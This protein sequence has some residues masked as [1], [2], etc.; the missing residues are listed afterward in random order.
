MSFLHGLFDP[1]DVKVFNKALEIYNSLRQYP[2][3]SYEYRNAL[4]KII[5]LCQEAV[6][7]NPDN[8]DG[9][10]LLA[11]TYLLLH[12]DLY[13]NEVISVPLKLAAA[14]IQYWKNIWRLSFNPFKPNGTRVYEMVVN[15]I[16]AVRPELGD[17]GEVYQEMES[18]QR[19]YDVQ[20]YSAKTLNEIINEPDY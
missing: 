15:A 14:V 10:V 9:Y 13:S 7:F 1:K 11:N 20:A 16:T 12:L 8:E 3:F 4:V 5:V 19:V 6:T 17:S 18:Y 2:V